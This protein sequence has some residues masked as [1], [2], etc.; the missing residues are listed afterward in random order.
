[1][2]LSD[3]A[4]LARTLESFGIGPDAWLGRGGEA[5]I[6]ALDADRVLRVHHVDTTRSAVE[7]RNALLAELAAG[8]A[9]LPFAIPAVLDT[10]E[11]EGRIVVLER[12]LPGRPL[13]AVLADA[14]AASRQAL[15]RAHL[16][17]A[18]RIGDIALDR[19]AY[20]D[21]CSGAPIHAE[22]FRE[23][24]EA[25]AAR[26][27]RRAGPDFSGIDP[28]ELARA[29]PE[30]EGP[31]LVHL[32]AFAGNMLA[33]GESITAVIDFGTVSIAGDRRLDPLAA[34]AYLDP[35]ITPTATHADRSVAQEWLAERGLDE[36]YAPARRWLA[37]FWS[38]AVDD[39]ALAGWCRSILLA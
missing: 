9:Q 3:E 36:L 34:A 37:A 38:A 2:N 16:D 5:Q 31:A 21:L 32:D 11:R 6:Y 25:R 29:L 26:S 19:P 12:R 4:G 14:S 20:G 17:A 24:L 22:T 13:D 39:L 27:L 23:Y 15:V 35:P 10:V 1:M 33:E 30:P 8:A 18:A 28:G 7:R